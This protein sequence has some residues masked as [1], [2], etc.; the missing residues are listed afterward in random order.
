MGGT[1]LQGTQLLTLT[2]DG[3]W[4]SD[5]KCVGDACRERLLV[6]EQTHHFTLQGVPPE[7]AKSS[8]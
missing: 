6:G 5:N 3:E 7:Q 4:V 1:Q 8:T 2:A